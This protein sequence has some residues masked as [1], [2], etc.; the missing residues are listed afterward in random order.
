MD[1]QNAEIPEVVPYP[2][3]HNL[4]FISLTPDE[5]QSIL[6]SL[7]I[8]KPTGP[9]GVSNR[10]LY[11]LA[12]ELSLPI[13]HFFNQSL[14]QGDVPNC[15]KESYVSPLPK[16]GDPSELSNYRPISLLSNLEKFLERAVFKYLYNHF[17]D[18]NILKPFQSGF[19]PGDSTVNQLI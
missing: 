1:D 8:G 7:S 3:L 6:K 17:R 9:D 18:N 15:F 13:C 5:V 4:D 12:N 19:I 10:I 16:G 2:V 11:A 14:N